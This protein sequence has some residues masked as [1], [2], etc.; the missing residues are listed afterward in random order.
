MIIIKKNVTY[1][2]STLVLMRIKESTA[3]AFNVKTS[4]VASQQYILQFQFLCNLIQEEKTQNAES[5]FSRHQRM[6][7][8]DPTS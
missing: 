2:S 4:P 6:K 5:G 8:T 3:T 7:G 1:R